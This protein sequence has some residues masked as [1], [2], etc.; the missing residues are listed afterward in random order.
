MRAYC[1]VDARIMVK[2]LSIIKMFNGMFVTVLNINF[3]QVMVRVE[4]FSLFLENYGF[5][6]V[7][8]R[9]QTRLFK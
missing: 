9:S 6:L 1:S 4:P 8:K 7:A 2:R 3:H 5:R